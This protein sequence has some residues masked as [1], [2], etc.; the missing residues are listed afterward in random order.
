[1][2][3]SAAQFKSLK[4]RFMRKKDMMDSEWR[5]HWLDISTVTAPRH[6]RFLN[7]RDTIAAKG[8]NKSKKILNSTATRAAKIAAAGMKGGLTPHS[9]PWF[10]LG[11]QD[12]D[13]AKW[14]PA[15]E[16]LNQVQSLM[17]STFGRS[18]FYHM[19]HNVYYEELL[20]GTGPMFIGE[21]PIKQIH[22]K[23]WTVGEYV[24]SVNDRGQVDAAYRWY[25]QS[26]N[27]LASKFGKENLSARS[28][29]LCI[30]N[31]DQHIQIIHCVFNREDNDRTKGDNLNFDWGSLYWEFKSSED[32]WLGESGYNTNPLM[33]PRWDIVGE[34]AYGSSCPGMETLGDTQM[35]QKMERDKLL[36]L[37]KVVDPP[38]NVPVKLMGRLSTLPGTVNYV[39]SGDSEAIRPTYQIQPD[40]RSAAEEIRVVEARIKGGYYNDLFLMI[41]DAHTMTATEVVQRHEDKLSILGPVIERQMSELLSPTIDRTFDVMSR[42]EWIPLPPEELIDQELE[43]EYVSLLAQAQK[44]VG[45]QSIE[46]QIRMVGE[47]AQLNPD[48]IDT[49]DFDEVSAQY[50]E[51]N[52]I[53]PKILRSPEQIKVIRTQRAEA[54]QAAAQQDQAANMAATGK[55]LAQIP[56]GEGEENAAANILGQMVEGAQ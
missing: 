25:W 4:K 21:D 32:K 2:P 47:S 1:M 22:C 18:N 54:Q 10:K 9:L 49:I 27:A 6:G 8:G 23:A 37:H 38:M 19:I 31:P 17:Y 35:L 46:K 30:T 11:L 16:W 40:I 29:Q 43:V 48:I 33:F 39:S 15:R 44:M 7:R 5:D 20:F 24:V 45:T 41:M 3:L 28:Q 14:Q 53:P 34:D 51:M 13:L 56:T 26:V 55:D 50:A 52:G 36:G 42:G 12:K